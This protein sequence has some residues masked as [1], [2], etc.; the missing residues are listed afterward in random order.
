MHACKRR[1]WGELF[2]K[3]LRFLQQLHSGTYTHTK[4]RCAKQVE[5]EFDRTFWNM[6]SSTHTP[7]TRHGLMQNKVQNFVP[8]GKS[9]ILSFHSESQ[10]YPCGTIGASFCVVCIHIQAKQILTV[11]R[12]FNTPR[13]RTSICFLSNVN[14]WR[15]AI[16]RAQIIDIECM[17]DNIQ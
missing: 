15:T 4:F 13:R 11:R 12:F 6:F 14:K 5:L 10:R 3:K 2:E 17:D 9:Y 8:I 16:T 7:C 1:Y